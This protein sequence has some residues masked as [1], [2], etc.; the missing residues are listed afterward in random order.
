MFWKKEK[1]AFTFKQAVDEFSNVQSN[2]SGATRRATNMIPVA[3]EGSHEIAYTS[4]LRFHELLVS[5]E[6]HERTGCL[7]VVSPKRKSR[8]AILI[9]KGRVVGC[10]Y[11]S[12]RIAGHVLQ[13]DA[14]KHIYADLAAPG[15]VL[16]A[17]ELP[18]QL[19]LAAAS[20]FEGQLVQVD[21]Q[22]KASD[23]M[24]QA[25][26]T[27]AE[28]KSPGC[29]VLSTSDDDMVCVVYL[30]DGK[31]IGVFS[32]K[33]GWV[34]PSY[35]AAIAYASK[36]ERGSVKA[37]FMPAR[38]QQNAEI[39]FSLTGLADLGR[40]WMSNELQ[41]VDSFT[42]IPSEGKIYSDMEPAIG[43]PRQPSRAHR[44]PPI[45]K[46]AISTLPSHNVFAIAP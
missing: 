45:S 40:E 13:Q 9:Y 37:A 22:Q 12:K 29:A 19:V 39:G 3:L 16:D 33:D 38:Q 24:D 46:D 1:P 42:T 10:V 35:E 44:R 31:I 36:S 5:L 34:K 25:L 27:I 23:M 30:Q 26:R 2:S 7:R 11:G 8:S 21:R 43:T 32:A 28:T 17:Y 14:L 20:L 15:N 4:S 18:E 6:G 41:A